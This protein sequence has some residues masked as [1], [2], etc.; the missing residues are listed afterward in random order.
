[1]AGKIVPG[2]L[3]LDGGAE[4]QS[5][6]RSAAFGSAIPGAGEADEIGV[7]KSLMKVSK[8]VI[9]LYKLSC[10]LLLITCATASISAWAQLKP[11]IVV[12]K[13]AKNSEAETAGLQEGDVLLSWSREDAEGKVTSPFDL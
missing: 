1:M 6:E 12:E 9:V 4:N 5:Y 13:V 3:R 2:T 7:R 10:A 11:G 8:T